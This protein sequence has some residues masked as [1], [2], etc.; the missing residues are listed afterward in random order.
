MTE[1]TELSSKLTPDV[2]TNLSRR[3]VLGVAAGT[4]A[5]GLVAACGGSSSS[6]TAAKSSDSAPP[7]S[8]STSPSQ[9][10]PAAG[11]AAL[12]KTADVPVGG[13]FID[14]AAKIVVTQPTA[15]TY[16]GF[17]A[18]CT[19]QGCT[20]NKVDKGVIICPCHGSQYSATDGSVK[21]GPAPKPLA[22]IAVK[23]DGDSIVKA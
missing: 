3:R 15:G 2:Q 14:A 17:T 23:V 12:A 20:V 7:S 5:L 21:G 8:A 16:K 13:G 4:G 11:G 19:H 1:L 6:D 9:S 18:I 10:A 22:E